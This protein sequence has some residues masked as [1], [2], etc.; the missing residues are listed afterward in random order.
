[1]KNFKNSSNI[2]ITFLWSNILKSKSDTDDFQQLPGLLVIIL[3]K[4]LINSFQISTWKQA[5]TLCSGLFLGLG[6]YFK[7]PMF[8]L[9]SSQ[10]QIHLPSS[11]VLETISTA[12]TGPP[13]T[14][15]S[16]PKCATLRRTAADTCVC[17]TSSPECLWFSGTAWIQP[18]W[19]PEHYELFTTRAG[20]HPT[21]EKF[22]GSHPPYPYTHIVNRALLPPA[23]HQPIACGSL[24]FIPFGDL[25]SISTLSHALPL[26]PLPLLTHGQKL[27]TSCWA[28]EVD[29]SQT[30]VKPNNSSPLPKPRKALPPSPSGFKLGLSGLIWTQW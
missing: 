20:P 19:T 17:V 7:A 29:K 18:S 26:H 15:H 9:C 24:C 8:L 21:M 10:K 30:K 22:H 23:R 3:F 1:M 6:W 25:S 13:T 2:K 14:Y 5:I 12:G 27:L 11:D 4:I 16:P 28:A